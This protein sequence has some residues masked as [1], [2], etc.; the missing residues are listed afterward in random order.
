M[1][2]IK[3]ATKLIQVMKA[4]RYISKDAE[5][6]EQKYK[7][8][9]AAAVLEK[10]NPALVESLLVS[11]PK[12]SVVS[13]KEKSTARG[14]IW[15]LITVECQ[16]TIIDTE[17]GESVTVTSLGTGT[18]PGDKATSKAQTAALK[19]AWLTALNIETG[20]EPETGPQI[21]QELTGQPQQPPQPP[22]IPGLP[23]NPHV[24][25]LLQLCQ[26]LGWDPTMLPRYLENRFG[27]PADQLIDPELTTMINEFQSY[28]Q[29]RMR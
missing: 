23:N 24:N 27:K 14:G 2:N 8:V 11:V 28:L 1:G 13:E 20:D 3:I 12:F 22:P 15:Q 4:C 17:S 5:N 29:Q 19:Y 7:Y 16:L 25:Q 6:K 18:D 10:V 9:S 21:N 26:Q